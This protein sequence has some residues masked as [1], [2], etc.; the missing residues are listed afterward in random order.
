MFGGAKIYHR[1]PNCTVGG[2]TA[3]AA[4]PV[5]MPMVDGIHN[6]V[7][8]VL[9]I[10]NRHPVQNIYPVMINGYFVVIWQEVVEPSGVHMELLIQ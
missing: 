5:P 8:W 7:I 9:I 6:S 4:P 10:P 3:P 1:P 2:T